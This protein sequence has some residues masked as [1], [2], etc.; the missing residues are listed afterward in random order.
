MDMCYYYSINQLHKMC[1]Q[2]IRENIVCPDGYCFIYRAVIFDNQT[3]FSDGLY[4]QPRNLNYIRCNHDKAGAFKNIM[5]KEN[6]DCELIKTIPIGENEILM[7]FL[8]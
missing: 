7:I 5:I 8:M 2:I 1:L 3:I 6:P 4:Y